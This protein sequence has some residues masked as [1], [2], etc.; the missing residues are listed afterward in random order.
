MQN[1][2]AIKPLDVNA[3][4]MELAERWLV[5]TSVDK[6][7]DTMYNERRAVE[8]FAEFGAENMA[9]PEGD[10]VLVRSITPE[11]A[12]AYKLWL[13]ERFASNTARIKIV[14]AMAICEYAVGLDVIT[15]N[16]FARVEL[17]KV[18]FAGRLVSD[19]ILK[20]LLDALPR[21]VRR[22]CRFC[23]HTGMRINEIL[24]MDWSWISKGS[25][26]VPA[27]VAKS[28][29]ERTFKLSSQ[30]KTAMGPRGEGRVFFSVTKS[31][32]NRHMRLVCE[33][34]ELGRIRF[35]DL[36]HN[37]ATRYLDNPRNNI[38]GMMNQFDWKSVNSAVPYQ[39]MTPARQNGSAG[40]RYAF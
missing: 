31:T 37:A 26:T 35:H 16:P 4:W 5:S 3:H 38:Y 22:A 10:D 11:R 18:K 25:I 20:K 1:E 40:I 27:W 12:D 30:A 2:H 21:D 24:N 29:R 39:H 9:T 8:I 36:R 17:P 14:S 7:E 15:E 32:I 23:L 6:C 13:L 28:R 19:K 34:L 33:R